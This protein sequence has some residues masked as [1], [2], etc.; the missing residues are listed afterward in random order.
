MRLFILSIM[1]LVHGSLVG[2]SYFYNTIQYGLESTLLGGAVTAGSQDLSMVYYNPAALKYA[3]DKTLDLALLMPS[4][5]THNYDSFF[6]ED[7]KTQSQ[8]FSLNPSLATYKTTINNWNIV[9]TILQKDIWNKQFDYREQR[10]VETNL[11]SES[12]RY[13]YKGDEKWFGLG[14][15]IPIG[16]NISLG[17]SHF[18]SLLSTDYNYSIQ[19]ESVNQVTNRQRRFF[20][21]NFNLHYSST[22]SMVTKVGMVIEMPKQRFGMV[23]TTPRYNPIKSSASIENTEINLNGLDFGLNNQTDFDL[24][25]D[26]Q[27][28]WELSLGYTKTLPDSTQ[29]Y[30]NGSFIT[31]VEPYDLLTIANSDNVNSIIEGGTESVAN[32]SI[33]ISKQMNSK[34]QFLS[35]FR[36]NFTTYKNAT[37][38]P[39]KDRLH[40]I[41]SD[42]LHFAAGCKI[43]GRNASIVVGLDWGFSFGTS[44][45]LFQGFP[46]ID[47]IQTNSAPY[48]YNSLT[49][50]MTY[51]FLLD[52]V[53]RNVSKIFE[54][55]NDRQN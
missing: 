40:V 55:N 49:L 10:M 6:G 1:F 24:R 26:V 45:E 38:D 54:R 13:G 47:M 14:S 18:W 32:L 4:Y 22:L 48:R 44:D 27:Y 28:G 51:E 39:L 12:F 7:S 50:L 42:R 5:T 8:D 2:Q 37:Q 52:S 11:N 3:K 31:G 36:T 17:V 15:S 20:S 43:E 16:N 53:Q 33:G 25:P 29:L 23:I 46:N 34:L 21:Q 41:D 35:S 30:I 9:F 19:S